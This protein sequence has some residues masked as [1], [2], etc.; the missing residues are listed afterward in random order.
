MD[1]VELQNDKAFENLNYMHGLVTEICPNNLL[2]IS[3]GDNMVI[4]VNRNKVQK[5]INTPSTATVSKISSKSKS[6]SKAEKK[7]PTRL[8]KLEGLDAECAAIVTRSTTKKARNNSHHSGLKRPGFINVQFIACIIFQAICITTLLTFKGYQGNLRNKQPKLDHKRKHEH[9]SQQSISSSPPS[10][11]RGAPTKRRAQSRKHKQANPSA[12]KTAPKSRGS[13]RK[14]K[15]L[16]L[17]VP[18]LYCTH[19]VHPDCVMQ[20]TRATSI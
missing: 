9:K 6:K 1:L 16:F 10:K 2:K 8:P 11:V 20:P 5:W 12:K 15:E 14:K 7:R 3:L 19:I 18:Y 17:F 13:N 4:V